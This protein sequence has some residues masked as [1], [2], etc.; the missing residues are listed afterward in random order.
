MLDATQAPERAMATIHLMS[1]VHIEFGELLVP[2]TKADVVVLAGDIHVGAAAVAWS[3]RLANRLG[4]PVVLVA[5]NHEHYGS[6]WQPDGHM[7]GTIAELRAAADASTGHVTFLEREIAVV[8]GIRFVGCTLWTD[9]ELY[10]NPAED[11]A[12]AET[13]MSDYER[14]AYRPGVRFSTNDAR[15]E[16]RRAIRFLKTA[17]EQPFDGPTVVVTHHLPSFRSVAERFKGSRLNA[18][19]ASHLDELVA[20]SGAKLWCH[21]HTHSSFDYL[22]G[23]TRVL[24]NPR[25]YDDFALNPSFDPGLT[26]EV[27]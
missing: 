20:A 25:G 19:F 15:R 18:A 1:D 3:D 10:G 6:V 7:A 14:I 16:F 2:K 9:F 8:A 5:G 26:A 13:A 12:H 27:G 4:S 21:G 17:L 24:C 23:K 22:I 11:M